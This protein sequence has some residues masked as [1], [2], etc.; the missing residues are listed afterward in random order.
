MVR[1]RVWCREED[2]EVPWR[3]DPAKI[4]S[5]A[6]SPAKIISFSGLPFLERERERC[7]CKGERKERP[8]FEEGRGDCWL[9]I[10]PHT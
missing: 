4:I 3:H 8:E 9:Q 7:I 5:V 2:G 1:E 6:I 10:H